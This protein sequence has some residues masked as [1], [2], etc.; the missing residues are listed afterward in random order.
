MG[1][2]ALQ[3]QESLAA[4]PPGH[5]GTL[6]PLLKISDLLKATSARKGLEPRWFEQGMGRGRRHLGQAFAQPEQWQ[7]VVMGLGVALVLSLPNQPM[8]F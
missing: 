5:H 6:G 8:V 4:C 7:E 1:A 2:R 3:E